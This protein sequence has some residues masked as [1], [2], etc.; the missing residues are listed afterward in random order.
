MLKM[1]LPGGRE[2]RQPQKR[3]KNVVKEDMDME[4][5]GVT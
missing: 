2:R 1:V 5:V 4:M 3:F